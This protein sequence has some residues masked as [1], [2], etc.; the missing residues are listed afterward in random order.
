MTVRRVP[1]MK[2]CGACGKLHRGDCAPFCSK[3]GAV[4]APVDD[5]LCSTC[6]VE[7]AKRREEDRNK[8]ALAAWRALL[9][10]DGHLSARRRSSI[11]AIVLQMHR[12]GMTVPQP[13]KSIDQLSYA[14]ERGGAGSGLPAATSNADPL[15]R[16]NETHGTMQFTFRTRVGGGGGG[17]GSGPVAH[18]T[19][20]GHGSAE[21][22]LSPTLD[23]LIRGPRDQ[24]GE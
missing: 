1:V 24:S 9:S 18:A 15:A 2:H 16:F 8:E 21:A 11:G 5:G 20:T 17:W 6:V 22:G 3:C 12:D 14:L 19:A 4:G 7:I 10:Q 23:Y 13:P